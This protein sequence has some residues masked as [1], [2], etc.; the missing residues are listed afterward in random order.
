M[1]FGVPG[2][3]VHFDPMTPPLQAPASRANRLKL[4]YDT[5]V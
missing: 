1:G 5:T 4:E 2:R 3:L